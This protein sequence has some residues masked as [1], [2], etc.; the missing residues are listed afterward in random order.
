MSKL[1]YQK[2]L[3]GIHAEFNTSSSWNCRV[4][5][6]K[7]NRTSLKPVIFKWPKFVYLKLTDTLS[8]WKET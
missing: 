6:E 3:F 5:L 7:L 2:S 4:D 8:K 1:V